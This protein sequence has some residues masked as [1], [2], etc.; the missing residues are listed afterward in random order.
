M[1]DFS[2]I[3]EL[4]HE[5]LHR[6]FDAKTGL[7]AL[8]GVHSTVLGPSLGG[9]RALATYESEEAAV[10]DVLRLSRGMTYKAS[11]AG[12]AL[13]GGKSVI[14]LP[15]GSFDRAALFQAFG[16]AVNSL[17]G[18]Y[19]SAEDSGTSPDDMEQVLK[20]TRHVVGLKAKS[21]DPSPVTA[22]GVIRSMEAVAQHLFGKPDLNGKRVT[23]LGVGHVGF[24]MV[25][26]LSKRG[27]KVFV[28]DINA[29]SVEKAVKQCGATA[30][31]EKEL[32]STEADIFSPCALG[33]GLNDATIPLLKVKAVVGA[34]NNQL[35]E[36]RHGEVLAQRGIAYAPDYAVNAGGLINCAS[37]VLGYGREEALARAGKIFDTVVEIFARARKTNARPEVVA[38]AM[39]EERIQKAMARA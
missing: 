33:G 28:S 3:S 6:F 10:F 15:K 11:L 7:R 8:I 20:H 24:P 23:V 35:L 17:G 25:E 14:M 26:E 39:A 4:G 12:L 34:A 22:Y 18:R 36:P 27:A 21:G 9:T 37:E 2:R 13:G 16:R 29:A 32:L 19:I 38:D 1:S 31:S 5:S 30:L